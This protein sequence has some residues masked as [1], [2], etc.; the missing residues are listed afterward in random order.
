MIIL[1]SRLVWLERFTFFLEGFDQSHFYMRVLPH[2][3][4]LLPL[5]RH[6][7]AKLAYERLIVL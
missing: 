1:Q 6:L 7:V 3:F 2:I 4:Q 5:L